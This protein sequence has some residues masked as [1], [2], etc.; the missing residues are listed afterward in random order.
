MFIVLRYF[1]L[2]TLFVIY[3]LY[4]RSDRHNLYFILFCLF[5]SITHNGLSPI[6]S[7]SLLVFLFIYL[8][9]YFLIFSIYHMIF[10]LS[11][12]HN[13]FLLAYT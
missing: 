9:I 11:D 2:R 3:T 10:I 7:K 8:F 13:N 5:Y 6:F 12:F 1:L 4:L